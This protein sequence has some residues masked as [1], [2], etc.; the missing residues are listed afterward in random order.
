MLEYWNIGKRERGSHHLLIPANS[1]FIPSFQERET[2]Y[3][4][5]RGRQR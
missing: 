5:I 3:L 1:S 4:A 2:T